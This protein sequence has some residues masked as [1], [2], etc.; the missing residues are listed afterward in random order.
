MALA[1]ITTDN[2]TVPEFL[3]DG[4]SALIVKRDPEEFVAA[5]EK[6]RDNPDLRRSLGMMAQRSV[7]DRW[8]WKQRA[9]DYREFFRIALSGK[10]TWQQTKTA[11]GSVPWDHLDASTRVAF[12]SEQADFERERNTLHCS[13]IHGLELDRNRIL[14]ENDLLKQNLASANIQ[15]HVNQRSIEEL[16]NRLKQSDEELCQIKSSRSWL[17]TR[18]L[19]RFRCWTRSFLS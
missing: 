13:M 2:G 6:L 7:T 1:I 17:W 15:L 10:S 8:D 3:T 16:T 18:P 9:E 14:E 19:A 12:L 4:E 11:T 5:V